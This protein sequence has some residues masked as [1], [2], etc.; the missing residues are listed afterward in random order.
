MVDDA[1]HALTLLSWNDSTD[2][3]LW[4]NAAYSSGS[5][6][7][8]WWDSTSTSGASSISLLIDS[9]SG[10]E[11]EITT[12]R[13]LSDGTY[14]VWVNIWNGTF[15]KEMLTHHPASVG[16]YCLK[17]LGSDGLPKS[18]HVDSVQQNA[19]DLPSDDVAW[20]KVGEW[21]KLA[22]QSSFAGYDLQW[23]ACTSGC[24]MSYWVGGEV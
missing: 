12:F 5:T 21:V 4:V 9:L 3:D 23:Q 22:P 15:T 8:V 24:Y 6:E 13:D 17:C 19:S 1:P 11:P 7:F 14:E 10:S 2:L 18:G 16:I 20:W